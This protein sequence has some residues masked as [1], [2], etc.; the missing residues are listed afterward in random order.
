MVSSSFFGVFEYSVDA[1]GRLNIPSK[2]RKALKPEADETFFV[3]MGKEGCLTLYPLYEWTNLERRLDSMP[4]GEQKRDL[5]RYY[6]MNSQEASLDRQ[7][8]LMIPGEFLKSVGIDR[9][10]I[11]VGAMRTIEIWS[12]EKFEA[13][14]KLAEQKFTGTDQELP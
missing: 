3:S 12:P 1:K 4:N 2:F 5:I 7:G 11:V 6:S 13:R 10:V 14:R 9:E 8:R